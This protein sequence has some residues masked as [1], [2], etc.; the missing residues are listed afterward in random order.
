[1]NSKQRRKAYRKIDRLAGKAFR[2]LKPSGEV[3]E[4]IAIGRT[5]PVHLLSSNS[6]WSSFDGMRPSVHRIEC[7]SKSGAKI[8]PRLSRLR[9]A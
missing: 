2:L 4:V 5:K 6:D 1:M 9:V 8:S 7:R 3:V